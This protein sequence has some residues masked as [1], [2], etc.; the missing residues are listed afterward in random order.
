VQLWKQG[1]YLVSADGKFKLELTPNV[2]QEALEKRQI[3]PSVMLIFTVLSF[4]YGLKCLGGFSQVNYLTLMK[5]AYIKVQTERGNYKSIE[6]CARTQTKET[7]DVM[8]AFLGGPNGE[9]IPATG[10]D[11]ILYGENNR[12]QQIMDELNNITLEDAINPGMSDFYRFIYHGA[13]V[14]PK[15]AAITP[16]TITRLTGLDKKIR[17]CVKI[18][19]Q[20][21]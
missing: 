21:V 2:I 5:N 14:D 12:W 15:L 18:R 11:L 7:V 19:N 3:I 16:Q 1:D 17:P 6:V 13:E 8:I 10:L 20:V 4:Y 9:L